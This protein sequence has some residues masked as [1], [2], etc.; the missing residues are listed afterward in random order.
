GLQTAKW[1]RR[2]C[3]VVH[4]VPDRPVVSS[5]GGSPALRPVD[6]GLQGGNVTP[7]AVR[8][9]ATRNV[10]WRRIGPLISRSSPARKAIDPATADALKEHNAA[11]EEPLIGRSAWTR[12]GSLKS[13]GTRQYGWK[14]LVAPL[15]GKP[16]AVKRKNNLRGLTVHPAD[17]MPT[18]DLT[19]A[20]RAAI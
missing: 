9:R 13:V 16:L 14:C 20:E 2:W 11:L 19:D 6:V 15:V 3:S 7:H 4:R 5:L 8:A 12:K 18:I 10:W 1:T 17:A